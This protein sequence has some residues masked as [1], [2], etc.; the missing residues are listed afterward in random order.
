MRDVLDI[1]YYD[2]TND[3]EVNKIYLNSIDYKKLDEKYEL[4][5]QKLEELLPSDTKL[6]ID[7]CNICSD[8]VG[9]A[10]EHAFK[11]GFKFAYQMVNELS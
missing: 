4:L 2:W 8:M 7:F 1:L 11:S 3:S 6:L 5:Y 10:D 9:L